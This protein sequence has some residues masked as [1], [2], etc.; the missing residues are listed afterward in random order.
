MF[1]VE[2]KSQNVQTTSDTVS[3]ISD[4]GT[5]GTSASGQGSLYEDMR[6]DL[7]NLANLLGIDVSELY[8]ERFRVDRRKLEKLLMDRNSNLD[9]PIISS[10]VYCESSALDH[11]VTEAATYKL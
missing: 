3:E 9:L 4:C 1:F 5:G 10:L 2:T 6:E 7:Q 8:E 11:A